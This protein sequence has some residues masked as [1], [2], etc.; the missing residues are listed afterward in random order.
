MII[1]TQPIHCPN[2]GKEFPSKKQHRMPVM[3]NAGDQGY[4]CYC[5][6]CNWSGDIFPDDESHSSLLF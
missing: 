6:Q 4:D 1:I 3:N 2:C 5:P